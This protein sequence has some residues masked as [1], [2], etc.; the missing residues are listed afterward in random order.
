KTCEAGSANSFLRFARQLIL[1]DPLTSRRSDSTVLSLLR[2]ADLRGKTAKVEVLYK[3]VN[4]F[5][6]STKLKKNVYNGAIQ[7]VIAGIE[8]GSA[9]VA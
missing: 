8:G 7:A 5:K 2:D 4:F 9:D 1:S 6:K 3:V